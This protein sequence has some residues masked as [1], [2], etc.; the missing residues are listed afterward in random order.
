MVVEAGELKGGTGG[1]PGGGK[2]CPGGTLVLR[3]GGGPGGGTVEGTA[4]GRGE[5]RKEGSADGGATFVRTELPDDES[6]I[7]RKYTNSTS[8]LHTTKR[9]SDLL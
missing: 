9:L 3:G 8:H 7:K 4:D 6:E 1:L 2:G 5:V